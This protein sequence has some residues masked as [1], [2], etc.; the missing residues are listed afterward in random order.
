MSNKTVLITGSSKGI[1]RQLALEFA[2]QGY[3]IILHG[4]DKKAL[5][6]VKKKIR[7]KKVEVSSILGDVRLPKTIDVLFKIAKQKNIDILVNNVGIYLNK[8]VQETS[9]KE[10]QEVMDVNFLSIIKLTK[11]ILPLFQEKKSGL[12][13]NIN[14]MAG[15]QASKGESI[16]CAS[17]HALKGFFNCLKLD[18]IGQ[19]IRIVDFYFGAI[20]TQVTKS[21]KDYDLLI[22]SDEAARFIINSCE[23]YNSLTTSEIDVYRTKH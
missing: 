8:D 9:N 22:Q 6:Q 23:N 1:G 16:Y 17:K 12:I 15:K 19:K 2:N 14:S 13:V 5:E 21:R 7:Q 4:R 10:M 11:V 20:K 3:N 18:L